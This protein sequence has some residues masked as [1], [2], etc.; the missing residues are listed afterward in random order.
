MVRPGDILFSVDR[1]T[2][3]SNAGGIKVSPL[4]YLRCYPL[5]PLLSLAALP[6][7][8]VVYWIGSKNRFEDQ[9]PYLIAA[10]LLVLFAIAG[11][12]AAVSQAGVQ[13]SDG[14]TCPAVVVD[15][16]RQLIAVWADMT[17]SPDRVVPAIHVMAAPLGGAGLGGAAAGT[18]LTT[19]CLY[20]GDGKP[21]HW[22]ELKPIPVPCATRDRAAIERS[23]TSVP[24]EQW[25]A[26]NVGL[27]K[28]PQP[29]KPGLYFL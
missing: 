1:N 19:V 13:M 23:I 10:S 28:I 12:Y 26:L 5:V 7:A 24:T 27:R 3:A 2:R 18:R 21:G 15:P 22:T 17:T 11:N 4:R 16:A 9:F 20:Y 29:L 25:E 6:V 8:G 14:D